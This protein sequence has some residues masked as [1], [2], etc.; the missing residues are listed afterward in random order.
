MTKQ[1]MKLTLPKTFRT[2][3]LNLLLTIACALL[4]V[5]FFVCLL[6]GIFGSGLPE[7]DPN[8]TQNNQI[9]IVI[10]WV[11]LLPFVLVTLAP[12]CLLFII[13]H[14]VMGLILLNTAKKHAKGSP[15]KTP[16]PLYIISIIVRILTAILLLVGDFFLTVMIWEGGTPVL[17]I[18]FCLWV[19][20]LAF[21][22]IA[23]IVLENKSKKEQKLLFAEQNSQSEQEICDLQS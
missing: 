16:T 20:G 6:G 5:A 11:I 14:L 22:T 13:W 23:G 4:V 7:E 9:T 15:A 17:A 1:D 12:A 21:Y 8:Q 3:K 10:T 18:L 2:G 19:I